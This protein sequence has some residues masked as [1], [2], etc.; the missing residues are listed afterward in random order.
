M[1][2]I[3]NY[4]QVIEFITKVLKSLVIISFGCCLIDNI[5][6]LNSYKRLC[7]L[8]NALKKDGIFVDFSDAV[9]YDIDE[10][11]GLASILLSNGESI[12]GNNNKVVYRDSYPDREIN[13]TETVEK[14][15]NKWYKINVKNK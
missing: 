11:K 5:R 4:D 14:T 9:V 15:L 8:S 2:T 12:F 10:S 1:A 13:I 3:G 6:G 7:K